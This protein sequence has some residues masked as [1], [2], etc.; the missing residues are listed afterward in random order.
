MRWVSLLVL[1]GLLVLVGCTED[2]TEPEPTPTPGPSF[3]IALELRIEGTEGLYYSG[4]YETNRWHH[5]VSGYVPDVYTASF[6]RQ[7]GVFRAEMQKRS[8]G[9]SYLLRLVLNADGQTVETA[10]TTAPWSI[11]SITWSP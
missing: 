3:P 11:I 8:S 7:D 5:D 6:D 9:T 2:P 1:C 4:W 10:E